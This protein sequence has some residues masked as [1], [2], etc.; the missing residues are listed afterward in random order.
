MTNDVSHSDLK[1]H[2][3]WLYEGFNRRELVHPDPLEFLYLYPDPADMEIVG[4]VASSL[5]YG[6][7]AQI[8]KS[9]S[10]VLDRM[11]SPM[12]Y[13]VDTGRE[14]FH[15]DMR[16]FKHR[17]ADGDDVAELL[18]G[19]KTAIKSFGSTKQCFLSCCSSDDETVIPALVRFVARLRDTAGGHNS[20][21]LPCPSDGSPCKRLNLY[22]RWMIRNDDVDPGCWTGVTASKLVV[23]LDVHLHRISR[24][25][26]MTQ[27]KQADMRAAL[28]VTEGFRGIVPDDP[29]RYD[30]VLTRL[31]IR[32]DMK[33]DVFLRRCG[34]QGSE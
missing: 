16:G 1:P 18:F 29:V 6:R 21:L 11:G 15:S 19:I 28:E 14:R 5:A 34:V 25:L 23:P 24:A 22:L 10:D 26:G 30:F 2:L 27:R 33:P 9:V 17:F 31:G 13:V 20:H 4:L 32:G 8:L 12:R 3:D 7:V